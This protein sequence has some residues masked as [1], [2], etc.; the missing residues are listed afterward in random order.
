MDFA[1]LRVAEQRVVS[2]VELARFGGLFG[3]G[4][5]AEGDLLLATTGDAVDPATG[6]H[7]PVLLALPSDGYCS[8]GHGLPPYWSTTGGFG[9]PTSSTKRTV[10]I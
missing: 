7:S 8:C 6:R 4:T 10:I 5:V 9:V 3:L 1:V 2:R